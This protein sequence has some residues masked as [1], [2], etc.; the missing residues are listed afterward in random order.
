[1]THD[2]LVVKIIG[3]KLPDAIEEVV[4]FR[5]ERTIAVRRTGSRTSAGYCATTRR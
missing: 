4:D 2:D 1:M 5:G 3:D